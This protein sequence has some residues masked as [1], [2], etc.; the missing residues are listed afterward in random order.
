MNK[1][2]IV[3]IGMPGVG[4]STVGVILAKLVGKRF[5]DT[6]LVIQ[7][8]TGRLLSEIIAEQGAEG[9]IEVENDCIAALD[10]QD[11]V[12]ATGGSAVYGSE[13]MSALSQ[14]G[15]IVYLR[16]SY[17]LLESRLSDI[18]GRGVVT[19]PGQTLFDIYRERCPLYE[20]YADLTVDCDSSGIEATVQ[21]VTELLGNKE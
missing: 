8:Q 9:F 13:A 15:V 17:E 21:K 16:A 11:S 2:N 6:D 7:S 19:K 1:S 3:L 14:N 12:I 20:K 4:K 18:R 5:C 10:V